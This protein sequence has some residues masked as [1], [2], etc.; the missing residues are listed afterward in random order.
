LIEIFIFLFFVS[1]IASHYFPFKWEGYQVD[2]INI[3]AVAVA[4]VAIHFAV[5]NSNRTNEISE[6][7]NRITENQHKWEVNQACPPPQVILKQ[8]EKIPLEQGDTDN[9]VYSAFINAE[10]RVEVLNKSS[11]YS[12][13]VRVFISSSI[14]DKYAKP[15]AVA[16]GLFSAKFTPE[17]GALNGWVLLQPSQEYIS[18]N[19]N[20]YTV[21]INDDRYKDAISELLYLHIEYRY[22]SVSVYEKDKS[23]CIVLPLGS[24]ST[25]L[26]S[27]VDNSRWHDVDVHVSL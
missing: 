20:E 8:L 14:S 10:R 25:W 12:V 17:E 23:T 13:C 15:K 24:P 21:T 19:F 16:Q 27:K 22:L 26:Y 2:P 1:Q 3:L 18:E 11:L 7:Q 5:K 4:A 6:E 9:A